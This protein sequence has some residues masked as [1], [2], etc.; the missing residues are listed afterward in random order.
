MS[1]VVVRVF[2]EWGLLVPHVWTGNDW[3]KTTEWFT[4]GTQ[5]KEWFS[6]R[7]AADFAAKQKLDRRESVK[8][9]TTQQ[10]KAESSYYD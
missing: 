9:L 1:Y 3:M 5:P 8:V 6:R 4:Y 2:V 10:L 7:A